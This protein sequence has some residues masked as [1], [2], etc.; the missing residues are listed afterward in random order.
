M[1]ADQRLTPAALGRGGGAGDEKTQI[2][3]R[4]ATAEGPPPRLRCPSPVLLGGVQVQGEPQGRFPSSSRG[5]AAAK[6][7]AG[8]EGC[9]CPLPGGTW[10]K[11]DGGTGVLS[12]GR[13]WQPAGRLGGNEQEG[14]CCGRRC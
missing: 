4:T 2:C 3:G 13:G 5:F 12:A 11:R 1:L 10:Q 9:V 8:R 14:A 6:S 7:R